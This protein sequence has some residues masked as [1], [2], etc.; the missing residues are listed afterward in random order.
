MAIDRD[1]EKQAQQLAKEIQETKSVFYDLETASKKKN[2]TGWTNNKTDTARPITFS[3]YEPT[4]GKT[5]G[6][7]GNEILIDLGSEEANLSAAEDAMNIFKNG[8]LIES[9]K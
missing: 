3:A 4:T 2:V 7:K 5:L 1:L 6:G 9:S 8:E